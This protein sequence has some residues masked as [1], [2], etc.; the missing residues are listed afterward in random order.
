M[1][2]CVRG[3]GLPAGDARAER[4]EALLSGRAISC[5]E[6]PCMCIGNG[7][8]CCCG[9]KLLGGGG[10]IAAGEPYI[11]AGV[12]RIEGDAPCVEDGVGCDRGDGTC[13][14]N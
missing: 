1:L 4:A 2:L 10:G 5:P 12:G 13:D 11:G 3:G 9:C 8:V 14:G 6:G 7:D